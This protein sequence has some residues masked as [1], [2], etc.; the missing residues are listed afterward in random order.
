MQLFLLISQAKGEEALH[1]WNFGLKP[2]ESITEKPRELDNKNS[3]KTVGL[4][5]LITYFIILP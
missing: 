5:D 2:L 1:F 3:F 4:E